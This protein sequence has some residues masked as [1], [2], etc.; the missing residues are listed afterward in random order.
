MVLILTKAA[1]IKKPK[2]IGF[3]VLFAVAFLVLV[4]CYRWLVAVDTHP[5]DLSDCSRLEIRYPVSTL[6]YFLPSSDIQ[7]TVFSSD[8]KEY[9]KSIDFFTLDDPER[10][11]AFACDVSIGSYDGYLWGRVFDAAPVVGI[12]CY[13]DNEHV[14]SFTV[15]GYMIITEDKRLFKYPEDLPDVKTIEPVEMQPFKL[16]FQCALNM[17]GIYTFGTLYSLYRRKNNPYPDPAEWCDVIMRNRATYVSEERM[18]GHM[19][20]PLGGEGKCHYAMNPHCEPN[21]PPDTVLLFE[22]EGGWNKHG[23]P[24]FFTFDHHEPRGG[25]VLLNDGTSIFI[26]T[27]D[28]LK[29]L[30]WK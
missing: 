26:R 20:C 16:R 12:D 7:D 18:R 1:S 8:E 23:G 6:D 19:R 14:A 5:P 15:L 28:E 17:Q 22:T 29:K 9:I 21:S 13:R 10:I 3:I 2:V 11:Q 27:E 30:R 4:F 24:E 25:C